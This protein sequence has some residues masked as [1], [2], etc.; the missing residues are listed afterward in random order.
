MTPHVTEAEQ[1]F[2][3]YWKINA[4]SY[5][6]ILSWDTDNQKKEMVRQTWLAA[7]TQGEAHGVAVGTAQEREA[8]AKIIEEWMP[9]DAVMIDVAGVQEI[10]AAIRQRGGTGT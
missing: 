7:F 5:G 6:P 1:V 8:C 2:E 3:A 10:A 4:P 9:P